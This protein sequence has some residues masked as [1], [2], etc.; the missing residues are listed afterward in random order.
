MGLLGLVAYDD[1]EGRGAKVGWCRR[2]PWHIGEGCASFYKLVEVSDDSGMGPG[3][4][5]S[6]TVPRKEARGS[7]DGQHPR[8]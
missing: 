7:V 5:Q 8:V 6:M 4:A 2:G 3:G 1:K